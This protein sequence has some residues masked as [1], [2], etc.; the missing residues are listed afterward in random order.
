MERVF[1][2]MKKKWEVLTRPPQFALSVQAKIPPALA[3][4]HNFIMEHDPEDIEQYLTNSA[5][6]LDPN[7]G[8][9]HNF[10]SYGS[11]SQQAVTPT[12]KRRAT[13]YRD[14]L[15][16]AMWSQYTNHREDSDSSMEDDE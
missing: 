16:E 13:T 4:I 14:R 6:D 5:D 11:L 2:V 12:E 7:P 15:A 9:M 3:A 8:A 10:E 1:G